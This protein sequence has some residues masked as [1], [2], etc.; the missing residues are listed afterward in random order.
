[1]KIIEVDS[2][3]SRKIFIDIPKQLYKND[4]QWI[5]PL[6][7]DI[8]AVFNP[9]KNNFHQYGSCN[10][11]ILTNEMGSPIGR[12]AAFINKNKAYHYEQPTGGCGFFDCV[13]NQNAAN[14]LFDTAKVWLEDQG[15]QAM[16]GPINF[17]ENDMWWGLLIEG[18]TKPYYGMNYNFPYYKKLFERYGFKVQYEQISNKLL[19]S[20]PL[21]ERFTK[22]AQWVASKDGISFEYFKVAMLDKFADD[23][24]SIY[25]DAWQDFANFTP[26][27]KATISESFEKMK[28]ILDEKLIWFAYINGEPASFVLIL[29]DTNELINGL[30]GKMDL[31]GKISFLWNRHIKKNKK[32]RAVIMGT[33]KKFQRLGLESAL[34]IKLKE[35]VIPLQQYE[36]LELSWVGDF[37]KPM[38][39]IHEAT[40]ASFSKRHATYRYVFQSFA[41]V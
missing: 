20:K 17:G 14:L 31:K 9:E 30:N 32:M 38:I 10:R 16:D 26:I 37:N 29:P 36:E 12:I 39:A 27:T 3:E 23:F 19:I 35:Y 2:L 6:D 18:F 4:T 5:C 25:T 33:K 1:M 8:E 11:W 40:G 13:D 21:P 34:F 22:I 7:Q 24:I 15:M 28:P 41:K